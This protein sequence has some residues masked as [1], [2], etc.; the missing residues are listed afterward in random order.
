MRKSA[1]HSGG[2][3]ALQRTALVQ[4]WH[5]I[6]NIDDAL[7]DDHHVTSRLLGLWV[8]KD[9][10]GHIPLHYPFYSLLASALRDPAST[11]APLAR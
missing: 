11:L 5:D 10:G 9:P 6:Q 4:L 2:G 3:C 8:H 7:N 1:L